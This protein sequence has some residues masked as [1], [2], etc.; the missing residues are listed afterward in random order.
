VIEIL[1]DDEEDMLNEYKR[2]EVLIKIEPDQTDGATAE[3]ESDKRRSG[4]VK[5]AN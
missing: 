2:E 1:D 5:I 3:L 4:R